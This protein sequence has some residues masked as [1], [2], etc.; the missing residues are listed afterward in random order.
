[1]FYKLNRLFGWKDLPADIMTK[2]QG[3]SAVF[4]T[5]HSSYI[6]T[7]IHLGYT[8]YPQFKN[9][10]IIGQHKLKSWPYFIIRM[11]FNLLIAPDDSKRNNNSTK[12]MVEE[13]KKVSA[14]PVPRVLGISPKGYCIKKE[15][16]S[17]YYYIAKESEAKIYPYLVDYTRREVSLGEPVDPAS[18]TLEE[19]TNNLQK[20]L[21]KYGIL[22]NEYAEYPI[23]DPNYCPYETLL[24]F[25]MCAV[26]MSAFF[27]YLFTLAWSGMYFQCALSTFAT[28]YVWRYHL[29]GE[30]CKLQHANVGRYRK[31]EAIVINASVLSHVFHNLYYNG[32]IISRI[33]LLSFCTA[34]MMLFFHA[35][36]L[37]RG[38][39]QRR[40]K[41]AIFRAAFNLSLALFCTTM[42]Y[43]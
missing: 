14:T 18:M 35:N 3:D 32:V 40:G 31:Q 10:C 43:A 36:C 4:V 20:Q 38:Y 6:D 13:F 7:I 25:D 37:P 27:P 24:P 19:C 8:F 26:S 39:D 22:Y 29:N 42:T 16:R 15:W 30:G 12:T 11:L 17:G 33:P 21:G 9:V 28:M 5:S 23:D 34:A 41:Y 1:M 2:I